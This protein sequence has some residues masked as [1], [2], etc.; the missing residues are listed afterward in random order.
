[1]TCDSCLQNFRF[2]LADFDPG[3]GVL[4]AVCTEHKQKLHLHHIGLLSL[5]FSTG[6]VRAS[7]TFY[8]AVAVALVI[9]K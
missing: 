1:M 2:A 5:E 6:E 9:K 7:A 4:F 8:A 3:A